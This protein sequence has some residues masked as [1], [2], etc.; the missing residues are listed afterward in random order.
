MTTLEII[1]ITYICIS[2]ILAMVI[3]TTSSKKHRKIKITL[4]F[5]IKPTWNNYG[6]ILFTR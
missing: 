6:N 5:Y 3:L 4:F 1:L 2:Q